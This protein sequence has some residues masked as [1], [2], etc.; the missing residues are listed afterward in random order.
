MTNSISPFEGKTIIYYDEPSKTV[1]F[2]QDCLPVT[3]RDISL[4]QPDLT[5]I[6]VAFLTRKQLENEPYKF[7]TVS[8]PQKQT[9]DESRFGNVVKTAKKNNIFKNTSMPNI[10]ADR[11]LVKNPK[12]EVTTA[13]PSNNEDQSL[14][15]KTITSLNASDLWT[16]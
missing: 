5:N 11:V 3:Y 8:T 13:D 16:E 4:N 10:T 15:F 6:G 9:E 1:T 12:N 14:A 2:Q 7:R